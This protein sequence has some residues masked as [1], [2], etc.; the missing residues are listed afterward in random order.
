M[1]L[2]RPLALGCLTTLALAAT[3][4]R[5]TPTTSTTTTTG[6]TTSDASVTMP[7]PWS[8][9]ETPPAG[10][11]AT[12]TTPMTNAAANAAD[13]MLSDAQI[14]QVTHTANAGEVG[15]ARLAQAKAQDARVKKLAAMIVA[16]HAD[17]DRKGSDVA[18]MVGLTLADSTTSTSL[19]T[20]VAQT[21]DELRMKNGAE[22]DRAY[23]DAQIKE[24]R[25]VL[26]MIDGKLVPAA[27][28]SD[29]RSF[30]L[31][32]RPKIAEHL[33]DAERVQADM[34]K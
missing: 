29:V 10:V 25:A 16:E 24:H 31:S 22:F 18:K 33:K 20:D 21:T 23:V 2:A 13:A 9:H 15:Q 34:S 1:K 7:Y 5:D 19:E 32:V 12:P 3:G 8:P 30:L 28:D 6:A 14:L 4:C 27:K 11:P 17:A 26:D